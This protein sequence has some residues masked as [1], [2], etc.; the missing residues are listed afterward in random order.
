MVTGTCF[1]RLESFGNNFRLGIFTDFVTEIAERTFGGFK[2]N[3]GNLVD[4]TTG[5]QGRWWDILWIWIIHFWVRKIEKVIIFKLFYNIYTFLTKLS[6]KPGKFY[7]LKNKG[8]F[9]N[10]KNKCFDLFYFLGFQGKQ[11]KFLKCFNL[12]KFINNFDLKP[13]LKLNQQ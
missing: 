10:K 5:R 2:D 8:S 3:F 7:F 13:C 6:K 9:I 4:W 12:K 1:W 11:Y